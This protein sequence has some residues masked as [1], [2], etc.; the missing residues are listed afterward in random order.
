MD[1]YT[2]E[3]CAYASYPTYDANDY[4]AIAAADAGPLRRPHRVHGLRAGVGVQDAHRRG[5]ARARHRHADAPDQRHRQAVVDGG[6]AHVDDADHLAMGWMT[7]ADAIAYSRNVVAAKVALQPG[8]EHQRVVADPVR[9][10]GAG[11]ASGQPTGIDL[12]NEVPGIVRDPAD[13][14]LAR[15]RP[16]ER[17]VRA[18][19][20]GHADPARAGVRGDGQRRDARPAARRPVGRATARPTRLQRPGD[21]AAPSRDPAGDDASRHHRGRLLPRP[22][23]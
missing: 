10:P 17:G 16:R 3:I 7:F 8:Q 1:P 21:D 23:R 14:A 15:D 6:R 9:R 18:G 2:G 12:A 5:R 20:R 11:W 22:D 19:H 4:Q 13:H